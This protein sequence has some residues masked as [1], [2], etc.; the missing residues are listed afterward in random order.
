MLAGSL[1]PQHSEFDDD[2][3]KATSSGGKGHVRHVF[4]SPS[5]PLPGWVSQENQPWSVL[6][7]APFSLYIICV[8]CMVGHTGIQFTELFLREG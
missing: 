1:P 8:V 4:V 5:T 6:A 7:Q 3:K 2:E